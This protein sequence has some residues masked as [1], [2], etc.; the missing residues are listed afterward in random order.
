METNTPLDDTAR[1]S[2]S[3]PGRR[4][5]LVLAAGYGRVDYAVT[6]L[7]TGERSYETLRPDAP[8]D[9]Q[10]KMLEEAVY[11]KPGLLTDFASVEI[12]LRSPRLTVVPDA[13]ADTDTGALEAVAGQIW[14]D[15]FDSQL[16]TA[17]KAAMGCS[18]ISLPDSGEAGFVRRTFG[19]ARIV[20]PLAVITRWCAT[21]SRP[22]NRVKIYAFVSDSARQLDIV[23]M[24]ADKLLIANSFELAEDDDALYYILASVKASHFDVLDDELFVSAPESMQTTLTDSLRRYVNSVMPLIYPKEI[25][26]DPSGR[27][28]YPLHLMLS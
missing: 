19:D 22:V 26:C 27:P 24:T 28:L 16:I 17:D 4:R 9:S 21:L 5:R 23:A 7:Q 8:A 20:Q 2:L 15:D 13:A 1:R 18:I 14:G 6:D 25:D 3:G 11:L 12:M 10:L